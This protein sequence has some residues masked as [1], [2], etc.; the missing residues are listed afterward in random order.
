MN[1]ETC[2]LLSGSK[3]VSTLSRILGFEKLPFYRGEGSGRRQFCPVFEDMNVPRLDEGLLAIFFLL[4][5]SK[6]QCR[7]GVTPVL[8]LPTKLTVP[9]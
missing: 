8:C 2:L 7:K 3:R 6:V 9:G 5:R 4:Q 1:E